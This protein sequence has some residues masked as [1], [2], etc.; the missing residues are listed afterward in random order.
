MII[1]FDDAL[2]AGWEPLEGAYGLRDPDDE[3]VVAA[4]VVGGAGVIVTSD[5]DFEPAKVPSHIRVIDP[6]QFAADTADVDPLRAVAALR[7]IA[8]RSANPARSIDD[9]LALL[10]DRYGM[11]DAVEIITPYTHDVT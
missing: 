6:A 3:H 1:H 4:A 5:R 8:A 2:V 9:L 11:H 7:Q 10:R